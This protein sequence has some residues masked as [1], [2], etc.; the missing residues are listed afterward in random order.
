MLDFDEDRPSISTTINAEHAEHAE[1]LDGAPR[2]GGADPPIAD[3]RCGL[4]VLCVLWRCTLS[5]L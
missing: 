2:S 3:E 4:C 1:T 5:L